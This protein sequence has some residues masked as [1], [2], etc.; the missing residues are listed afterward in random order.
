MRVELGALSGVSSDPT[1]PYITLL[2]ALTLP[3]NILVIPELG[4]ATHNRC[5]QS[6]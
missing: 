2:K 4:W 1:R 6:T 3:C 5:R